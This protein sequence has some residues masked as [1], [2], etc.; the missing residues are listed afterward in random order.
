MKGSDEQR[1]PKTGFSD[2]ET[3]WDFQREIK[4]KETTSEVVPV[5]GVGLWIHEI[6]LSFPGRSRNTSYRCN[7]PASLQTI[8]LF[9]LD[10][11]SCAVG[12]ADM[13]G[14]K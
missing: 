9:V 2:R 12:E 11:L 10:S 13:A 4:R 3:N 14:R 8:Y 5:G 1:G 7:D 6:G